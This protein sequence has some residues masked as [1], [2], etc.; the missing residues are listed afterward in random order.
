MQIV[1]V[2]TCWSVPDILGP[3]KGKLT[4]LILFFTFSALKLSLKLISKYLK[5]GI[6][7]RSK[8]H[9]YQWL[10]SVITLEVTVEENQRN[11]E[12]HY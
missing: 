12:R 7:Y 8:R 9:R 2:Q 5:Y 4:P 1:S 10:V 6:V 3:D 11:N